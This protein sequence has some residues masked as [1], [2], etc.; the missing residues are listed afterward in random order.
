MVFVDN[1]DPYANELGE[2]FN[3]D[4][5]LDTHGEA[6]WSHGGGYLPS[7]TEAQT[8]GLDALSAAATAENHPIYQSVADHIAENSNS[9]TRL[10]TTEHPEATISSSS[11]TIARIP[12]EASPGSL[13]LSL[14][15]PNNNVGFMLNVPSNGMP[16][17][18]DPGLHSHENQ[19]PT[20]S[21]SQ[22]LPQ[23]TRVTSSVETEHEAAFF[24]RH[25]SEGP[26]RW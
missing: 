14:S 24:L 22:G 15:S 26:G 1:S 9:H 5:P 23:V 10:E 16:Q 3:T 2:H 19:R 7:F 6:A 17:P 18:I 8:H 20:S 21:V 25:F 13:S 4:T 11:P 12:T